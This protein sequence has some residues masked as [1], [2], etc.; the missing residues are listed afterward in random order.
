VEIDQEQ[1]DQLCRAISGIA[2]GCFGPDSQPQ[3]LEALTIK[4]GN[5][6]DGLTEAIRDHGDSL[7]GVALALRDMAAAIR[8]TGVA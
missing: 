3:G 7:D 5:V 6:G 1:L 8:E 2:H 4:L